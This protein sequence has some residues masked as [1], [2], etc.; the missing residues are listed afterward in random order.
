MDR[1]RVYIGV[2]ENSNQESLFYQKDNDTYCDLRYKKDVSFSEIQ[3]DSLIPYNKIIKGDAFFKGSIIKLYELDRMKEIS[4]SRTFIGNVC[5]I[6]DIKWRQDYGDF[7]RSGSVCKAES[8]CL[9]EDILLFSLEHNIRLAEDDF[10]DIENGNRYD[11]PYRYKVGSI[12]ISPARDHLR[13]AASVLGIN[14]SNI[15]KGKLLEKYREYKRR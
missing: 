8:I 2:Y 4:L 1:T 12:Y 6:I 7:W 14:S 11:R 10:K 9:K 13:P 3:K 15:Q 5:Q